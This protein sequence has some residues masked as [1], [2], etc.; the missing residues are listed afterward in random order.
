MEVG[1]AG[2]G[3]RRSLSADAARYHTFWPRV[4]AA[5]TALPP[6]ERDALVL[7]VWEG[8]GYEEIAQALGVPVGTVRSRLHRARTRL[9][10]LR[11]P[12]GEE[13]DENA[14]REPGRIAP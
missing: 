6:V 4:A 8:L 14:A 3:A 7:H 2:A 10:E 5:V 12:S 11:E 1:G 13:D 9:R